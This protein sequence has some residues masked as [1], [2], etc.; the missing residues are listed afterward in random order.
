MARLTGY[1]K[2]GCRK[3]CQQGKGCLLWK[4]GDKRPICP[5]RECLVKPVCRKQCMDRRSLFH[6]DSIEEYYKHIEEANKL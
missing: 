1:E 5:C 2:N 3:G 6:S 4:N